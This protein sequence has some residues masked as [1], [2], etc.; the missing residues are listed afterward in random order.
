MQLLLVRH[1][2]FNGLGNSNK[3]N[4]D[5]EGGDDLEEKSEEQLSGGTSYISYSLRVLSAEVIGC[6]TEF[7]SRSATLQKTPLSIVFYLQVLL[8]CHAIFSP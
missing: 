2:I 3:T 7:T 4:V 6:L 8:V 1:E 5:E